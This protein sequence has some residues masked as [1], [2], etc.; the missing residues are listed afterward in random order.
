MKR[1]LCV[2][3]IL[4]CVPHIV[5][6]MEEQNTLDKLPTDVIKTIADHCGPLE[7]TA[8]RET[9]RRFRAL[10]AENHQQDFRIVRTIKMTNLANDTANFNDFKRQIIGV[11]GTYGL[12]SFSSILA[13]LLFSHYFLR[14]FYKINNIFNFICP[15]DLVL[16]GAAIQYLVISIVCLL[17]FLQF[18]HSHPN[19]KFDHRLNAQSPMPQINT[20]EFKA[21]WNRLISSEKKLSNVKSG[22]AKPLYYFGCAVPEAEIDFMAKIFLGKRC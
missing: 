21:A 6:A 13:G 22:L 17:C 20:P 8:L 2:L 16:A 19:Q 18:E 5:M 11:A 1:S 9:C 3:A 15:V 7:R 12:C 4:C 14:H 10:L